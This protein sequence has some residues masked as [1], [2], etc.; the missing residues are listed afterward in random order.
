MSDPVRTR[1]K[2]IE[3]GLPLEATNSSCAEP[4]VRT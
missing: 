3:V 1:K 2:L 4:K